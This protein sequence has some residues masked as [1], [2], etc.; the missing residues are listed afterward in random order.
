V[1]SLPAGDHK[2]RPYA[3]DDEGIVAEA[4]NPPSFT[5]SVALY[6]RIYYGHKALHYKSKIKYQKPKI[7][8]YRKVGLRE[9]LNFLRY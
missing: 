4:S 6:G 3:T 8:Q 5:C 1:P 9:A 2:G 7:T